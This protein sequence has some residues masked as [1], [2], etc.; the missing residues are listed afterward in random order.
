[1]FE[2]K[3]FLCLINNGLFDDEKQ[4]VDLLSILEKKSKSVDN[5]LNESNETSNNNNTEEIENK[6][7]SLGDENRIFT[8]TL[9][10]NL[11]F[12]FLKII[13]FYINIELI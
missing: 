11:V 8:A 7:R 5:S 3:R 2:K 9:L 4:F 6:I 1:M 12:I 13:I 10:E